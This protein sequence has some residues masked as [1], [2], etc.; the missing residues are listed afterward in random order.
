MNFKELLNLIEAKRETADS[1]RRPGEAVKKDEAK[2]SSTDAKSKDAARKRVERARQIPRERKPKSEL[3]KEVIG[4]KTKSGAVQLIFKDSFSKENHTKITKKDS[5]TMDE[6]KS[7]TNDPKFEQTGASKLLFGNLKQKEKAEREPKA[8]EKE[9]GSERKERSSESEQKSGDRK[10]SVEQGEPSQAQEPKAKKL[11][12]QEIF[13]IMT[14]MGPEQLTQ[15]PLDVRQEYFKLTRNPPANSD[16]DS[17]TYEGIATKF[18]INQLTN[19]SYSQQVLNALLFLAKIKAGAS[20]QEMETYNALAP[21]GLDF[22]KNAFEHAR[23]ILSQLGE[24]C[25]QN[26]VS[27]IESGTKTT[28]AEGNVDMECGKYKFKISSGGEFSLSTDKFNQSG[29]TFRGMI[30]TSLS[31]S[32]Q[33]PESQNDPKVKEFLKSAT[34]RGSK[35]ADFLISKDSF[36]II[37]KNPEFVNRLKN[38]ELK[39]EAGNSLGPAIDDKGNLNKAASLEN[40]QA[41]LSKSAPILFKNSKDNQSEFADYFTQNILKTYFRGDNIK[42]PEL[43]PTHVV[44]QNGIFALNDAY[45]AEIAKTASINLRQASALPNQDNLNDRNASSVERLKRFTSIIENAEIPQEQMGIESFLV[46]K[47]NINPMAMMLDYI[48]KNMDFDIN[49]SLLP[50]F[51]PKDLNTIEY[52]YVKIGKKTVKI[53]VERGETLKHDVVEN[54]SI[55]ANDILIEALSNNFVL[56]SLLNAKL[57]MVDE[58]ETILHPHVLN[59]NSDNL[60]IIY[61]NLLERINTYPD[62]LLFVLNQYNRYLYEKYQR[63]YKME[64]RNYH[65]K[66]KQRKERAKRTA[67]RERLIKKGVVKKGSSKDVDHKKALRHG[68]SNGINNLRL[69]DK[70]ENR[71]DNGHKKGEKQK[72]D[73]K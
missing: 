35:F 64:Y 15:M 8:S 28:F 29:K 18:G 66:L 56:S 14:Q 70:S 47:K 48:S 20:Q 12:K 41:A 17:M 25:I 37:N 13:Q 72:K 3:V 54:A 60:K 46:M 71:S 5:I 33:N 23:K 19:T 68:G 69:R 1:F 52:N 57:L 30:A 50:G 11:S 34:E 61:Y 53:P 2:A 55:I 7:L 73:W 59:E 38:T 9:K 31:L 58:V 21:G 63:D 4:V 49:V 10:G 6:A 65:G 27:S 43:S 26:L 44:T 40:Y 42:S 51:A 16:F 39:D 24:E 45:F 32:F 36:S 67:A 22:T 62:N